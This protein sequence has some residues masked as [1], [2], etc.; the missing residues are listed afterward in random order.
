TMGVSRGVVVLQAVAYGLN[1][2]AITAGLAQPPLSATPLPG[3]VVAEGRASVTIALS[4]EAA[5][6]AE[7]A[8]IKLGGAGEPLPGVEMVRGFLGEGL[9]DLDRLW[10][11][12][13]NRG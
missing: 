8:G 6:F 4:P 1:G 7:R 12:R 9:C 2:D 5:S 10:L 11:G 3:R 13:R